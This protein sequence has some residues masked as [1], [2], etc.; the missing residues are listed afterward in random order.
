M[1]HTTLFVLTKPNRIG[2]SKTRLAK[3]VGRSEA[4]RI[5]AMS[6]AKVMRAIDNP[7]WQTVLCISPDLACLDSHPQWPCHILRMPQGD[8]DLGD[9]MTRAFHAAPL[10]NVLFTGTDMPDLQ[11]RDIADAI[12]QLKSHNAV[13]GPADD[14]GFWLFGLQKRLMTR[15][16]FENVRWSTEHALADVQRNLGATK[17]AH[18]R[19]CIDLDDAESLKRWSNLKH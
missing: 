7:R 5:N 9:R 10:G 18:L 14:G 17:T 3:D 8:G 11:T 4:R 12:I 16:P 15:P 13:F 2:L 6:N 19:T 1:P